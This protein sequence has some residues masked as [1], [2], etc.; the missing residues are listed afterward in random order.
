MRDSFDAKST[1]LYVALC[2]AC[3]SALLLFSAIFLPS[4]VHIHEKLTSV[5]ISNIIAI[6]WLLEL[7]RT[8]HAWKCAHHPTNLAPF[9][10]F[11]CT[12]PTARLF[13]LLTQFLPVW[14]LRSH[15]AYPALNIS[16]FKYGTLSPETPRTLS[17]HQ[18]SSWSRHTLLSGH[19][20]STIMAKRVVALAC[21]MSDDF[22]AALSQGAQ[23]RTW[24]WKIPVLQNI[25]R[26][27]RP[28]TGIS[29]KYNHSFSTS[30][31]VRL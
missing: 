29:V 16:L 11:C 2:E 10:F 9:S 23:K 30:R 17:S 3:P 19:K 24:N 1:T 5:I 20:Q 13:I 6:K 4:I 15:S 7:L 25:S 28:S 18:K 14:S 27:R 22:L 12:A 31:F 21:S 8:F 26:S